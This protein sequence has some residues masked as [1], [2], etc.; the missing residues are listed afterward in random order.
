[1]ADP[2]KHMAV[3]ASVLINLLHVSLL[4]LLVEVPGLRLLL[5]EDVH[6]EIRIPQQLAEVEAA[7]QS[8]QLEPV[9]L[10][11]PAVL[12]TFAKLRTSLGRGEASCLALAE[13]RGFLVASDEKGAFLRLARERLGQ[14]RVVT[15]PDLLL[16]AIRVGVLPVEQADEAKELLENRRFRM[17]FASFRELLN[18]D[19]HQR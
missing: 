10:D 2:P 12:E 4:G 9:R 15:T 8:G 17:P 6:A 3:D 16:M 7:I 19:P 18:K 11:D 1:M 14:G 5:T 13:H